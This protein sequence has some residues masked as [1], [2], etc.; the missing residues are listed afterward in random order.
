V[1]AALVKAKKQNIEVLVLER[2]AV[3]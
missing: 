3:Q 1:N 2:P